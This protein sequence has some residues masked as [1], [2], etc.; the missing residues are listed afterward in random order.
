VN[1][2]ALLLLGAAPVPEM[3]DPSLEPADVAA[4]YRAWATTQKRTGP[5]AELACQAFAEGL[6]LC[7]THA[8]AG[9]KGAKGR[10]YYTQ[11][12]G[13]TIPEL[14]AGAA[15]TAADA[16]ARME[17]VAVEGFAHGY[18]MSARGDGR[19]H[20]AALFPT[21]LAKLVGGDVVIGVPAHG[22]LIAWLPGDLDFDKV[23]AVGVKKMFETLPD[24]VSPLL[25]HW[26]G[27][28]WRTWGEA[29]LAPP[30]PTPPG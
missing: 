6:Q 22:V 11:A 4:Q 7:F 10:A 3:P 9:A 13:H 26:D 16:M 27:K 8:V 5:K 18:R 15:G 25:Y 14:M 24:P 12:D 21:E 19:D 23:V 17:P 2:L 20:V 30:A 29:K 28:L 1:V